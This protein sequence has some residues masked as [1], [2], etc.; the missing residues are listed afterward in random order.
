MVQSKTLAMK[1]TLKC[2]SLFLLIYIVGLT[3]HYFKNIFYTLKL[4][5][6]LF[7]FYGTFIQ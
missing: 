6:I 4:F 5:E 7:G 1:D 3:F 2:D